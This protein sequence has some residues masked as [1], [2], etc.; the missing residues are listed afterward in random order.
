MLK[1]IVLCATSYQLTAGIW[2]LGKLKSLHVFPNTAQ[3]HEEFSQLLSLHA[4]TKVYLLVDAVEEDYRQEHL[5]HTRGLARKEMLERKL[6]QVYRNVP[7][8]A[9]KFIE[10]E[11]DKRRDDRFIY[12]S[13]TK[14]DFLA[15]WLEAIQTVA[16]PLAGVYMLSMMS[17]RLVERMKLRGTHVLLSEK[18]N[19]GLRQS[20]F[21]QGRLMIS[22][23]AP[24]AES[25]RQRMGYFYLAETEKTRLYLISQRFITRETTLKMV[26]PAL[27]ESGRQLSRSIAQEQGIEC[28]NEDLNAFAKAIGLAPQLLTEYPELLHM[29]LLA[30]WGPPLNLAPGVYTKQYQIDM[31]RQGIN[32]ATLATI[33][34]GFS[35]AGWYAAQT[36]DIIKQTRQ[37]A[38]ET[39]RQDQLY[40]DVAKN[41]PATSIPS[42]DLQTAVELSKTIATYTATPERMMQ[43]ISNAMA[44][45]PDIQI[46]RLRW[47]K[48]ADIAIKDEDQS[49]TGATSVSAPATLSDPQLTDTTVLHEI[50]FI[51]CEIARFNGDYRAALTTVNRFAD[52][53]KASPEVALVEIV[54]AP[55][56]V[57]SYSDL[58]GSTSDEVS[59][60][61][62]AATFK[63]KLVLKREA[64]TQ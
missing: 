1:K 37:T 34:G 2:Q 26:L 55:V 44:D 15:P 41:F 45:W 63:I 7:F 28:V 25:M 61:S 50:G 29:H 58:Q 39:Q 53:L 3:G 38:A 9:A 62:S 40:R 11:P 5:P 24:I 21:Y 54:Q 42:T 49:K 64:L 13:L 47:V 16:L 18:L 56:N 27:D 36:G 32:A 19:S 35:L 48:S 14:S 6:N 30:K 17:E 43:V 60:R 10:R 22:R 8:K 52:K 46:N 31:I 4:H 33:V 20:Y 51:N 23:L 59:Q 57:S 12:L